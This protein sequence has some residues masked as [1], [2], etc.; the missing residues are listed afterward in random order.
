M[1]GQVFG[2]FGLFWATRRRYATRLTVAIGENLCLSCVLR[3]P[4][5]KVPKRPEPNALFRSLHCP[6]E[7]R[8]EWCQGGTKIPL[9]S[10]HRA[11]TSRVSLQN[12]ITVESRRADS[13][14]SCIRLTLSSTS[15]SFP[16]AEVSRASRQEHA[17]PKAHHSMGVMKQVRI[18]YGSGRRCPEAFSLS[19][20]CFRVGYR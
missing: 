20:L 18:G 16:R 3:L 15:S 4:T 13:S 17:N 19:K 8:S 5:S 12:R 9:V 1:V 2:W 10:T 11:P 14:R 6:L 7:Q